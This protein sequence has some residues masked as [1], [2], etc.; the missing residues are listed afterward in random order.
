MNKVIGIVFALAASGWAQPI[1]LKT[2]TLLDGRGHVLRNQEIVVEGQRIARVADARDPASYDLSGL[3]VMPGWIDTHVHIGYHFNA[4]NRFDD[5]GLDSKE[6]PQQIAL[7]AEAN[8]YATL[9]GGFTTVQSLGQQI[10]A[11]LR[12]LINAGTLPGPRILTSLRAVTETT[13]TPD[14]IR[15]YVR[16]MKD[17]GAD[18][19]KLFATASIR[20]G[21]KQTMTD[22]QVEAT[23]GEARA[24]GL[25]SV[26]HAHAPGGAR[27]AVLAGCTSIE[28]GAFLDDATLQM[29]ADHGLYF[30]PN[31]LVLHNYLD[32]KPKFLGIGNY[33]EQGFAYME[34]GIPM[35]AAVLKKAIAHHVKIIFGTD[36]VAGAHGRNAEEFIYRVRD[37]GQPPMDAIVSATSLAA[38][39]LRLQDKI[40]AVAPGMQADLIAVRGNP[41]EDI[42]SVRNVVFVMKAGQVF[43]NEVRK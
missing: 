27:A 28:H 26:V 12:G 34:K 31:F 6:T 24:L 36:A 21:G 10:D 30:D 16:K 35:M 9:Q 37:G 13:G 19:I 1:V 40:G 15:A 22:Q 25:R 32:N 18:V 5:G 38:E 29:I 17:D 33:N 8:A 43:R 41:L 20:D 4:N 23:C 42:T 2:S 7:R 11:D 39:S 3:T 14:Q